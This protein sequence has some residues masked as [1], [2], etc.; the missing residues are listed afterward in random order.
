MV[1]PKLWNGAYSVYE[2]Y[3]QNDVTD[4][5]NY[6]KNLGIRV[7]PEF[8]MPGHANSWCIGY[9]SIISISNIQYLWINEWKHNI[10]YPGICPSPSCSGP[11]NPA[12]NETWQLLTAVISEAAALFIDDHMHLG[13][14][15]VNTACWDQTQC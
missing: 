5:I 9:V 11:L 3:I 2:R 13:G 15:E 1:Y 6:A 4:I 10:R 8:D 7:I 14:D 12:A